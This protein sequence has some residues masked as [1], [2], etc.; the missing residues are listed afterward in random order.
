MINTKRLRQIINHDYITGPI[1]YWM[2]RDQRVQD[3][4]ALLYCQK[5]ALQYKV[6]MIVTFTLS[7]RFLGAVKQQYR[8]MIDGLMQVEYNLTKMNIHFQLL[9]GK[10]A[11]TLPRY[12]K[13]VKAGMLITDFDPIKIKC[14]WKERVTRKLNIPAFEV[15]SHNIVPC[16][17]ASNKQEYGA[18]TIRP[19]IYKYLFEL[20]EPFPQLKSHPVVVD[21]KTTKR[22]DWTSVSSQLKLSG[23]IKNKY[24]NSGEAEAIK[25]LN[26][27]I[28]EKFEAYASYGNNPS[29]NGT[30]DLSP[31]LHFGQISA[32]RIALKINEQ[33]TNA[34]SKKAFI[35]QL[36]VRRELS[37]NFCYYNKN[38][39]STDAFPDWAKKTLST[40]QA[41]QREYIYSLKEFENTNTHES[42]WNACQMEMM[43]KGKMHGYMRMYWAKKIFE[44]SRSAEDAMSIAM[45]LN[46][47]YSLDGRDPNGYT[48][49]AWAIGGVHDRAWGERQIFGKIRYMNERG[50]RAK[51]DVDKYIQDV[52]AL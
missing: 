26:R 19:K 21:Y 10:P 37:D 22:T 31:Y 8:F 25:I 36:I 43:K 30:S 50:C 38:Y 45:Y 40:H 39:D 41:D 7:P 27:F 4:W 13:K 3:N 17:I 42:L 44:W 46:D 48:G 34:D 24:F 47:R 32:Q 23:N 15:D 51:F 52:N 33:E 28:N 5:K 49:I 16:W 11:E 29:L 2:S 35:E 14:Q 1:V 12:L 6:P 20:L 9:V 18:Y